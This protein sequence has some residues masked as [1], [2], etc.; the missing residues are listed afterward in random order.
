VDSVDRRTV[1][2]TAPHVRQF[3]HVLEAA[4]PVG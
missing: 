1:E 4:A 3:D 2:S